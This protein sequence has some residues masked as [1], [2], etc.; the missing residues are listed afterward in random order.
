MNKIEEN[1]SK[2]S[3]DIQIILSEIFEFIEHNKQYNKELQIQVARNTFSYKFTSFDKL[4]AL[5]Y[6]TFN[7]QSRPKMNEFAEFIKEMYEEKDKLNTFNGFFELIAKKEIDPLSNKGVYHQLFDALKNR[8]GWGKKTSALLIKNLYNYH[9]IFRDEDSLRI[10]KEIPILEKKDRLF[11]PVDSVIFAIFKQLDPDR[12][13]NW[14]FESINNV[15]YD[16]YDNDQILLFDDLWFWGFIT[17]KG[18]KE[19]KFIWNESKYW[20]IKEANKSQDIVREIHTKANIFLKLLGIES[21]GD[22]NEP[23]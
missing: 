15:L 3:I 18:G 6:D 1:K 16:S 11:L 12:K 19:R 20:S 10:W 2:R 13:P 14:S 7:T 22:N 5:V 4:V 9:N 23:K 17:Q 21:N 8:K